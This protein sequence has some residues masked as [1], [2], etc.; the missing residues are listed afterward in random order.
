[1][2]AIVV[3]HLEFLARHRAVRLLLSIAVLGSGLLASYFAA[4]RM[5]VDF[6]SL[7][8]MGRAL[9]TQTDVYDP[10]WKERAFPAEYG[11][12]AP[13]GMF[14]PPATGFPLIPFGLLPYAVG[15][16]IWFVTLAG[17]VVAGVRAVVRLALPDAGAD[18]WM[19]LSGV[20]L[21]TSAM[22]WGMTPLQGA[23]FMFGLL[24]FFVVALVRGRLRLAAGIA[25][26]AM[27][28]K[29]T[30]A[31]P[32]LGL[33]ALYRRWGAIA[34]VIS[35]WLGL[36]ALGFWCMGPGA[37][38]HYR[39]GMG[40]VE[41]LDDINTPNPWLRISI[42][43]LD[44]KYLLY[45]LVPDVTLAQLGSLALAAATSA[46][47]AWFALKIWR[48]REPPSLE[49]LTPFV[50]AVVCLG[51]LCVYHHQYDVCL[52]LV[53]VLMTLHGPTRRSLPR[54]AW[55]LTLPLLVMM[56]ILPIGKVQSVLVSSFPPSSIGLFNMS[57]P[58]SLSLA[59]AGALTAL[60]MFVSKSR[61]NAA[62]PPSLPL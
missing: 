33:L 45:G 51:S 59:L 39:L 29:M 10:A 7:H 38:G 11:L 24:C 56:A 1:M 14:Y 17:S 54:A 18:V 15:K 57:F 61:D 43:R 21:M 3:P 26:L 13:P 62:P 8:A 58:L 47:L 35:S 6:A 19:A 30:L 22:R 12:G 48:K 27:A 46:W 52:F 31:L 9:V 25:V 37:L 55:L 42:P 36:N 50:A 60:S 28:F 4:Q 23:P 49:L 53:P 44:W 40:V 20:V 5:G 34:L 41:A 32:F 16:F 2:R